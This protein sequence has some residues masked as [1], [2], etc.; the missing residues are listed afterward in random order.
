MPH[1][2]QIYQFLKILLTLFANKIDASNNVVMVDVS[3]MDI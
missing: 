1:V 3:E 2:S